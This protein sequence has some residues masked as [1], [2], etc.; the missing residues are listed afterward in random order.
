[1]PAIIRLA[2]LIGALSHALDLTGGQDPGHCIRTA[3]IGSAV[4]R[5]LGLGEAE[6]HDLYYTLML[7]DLGCSAN[8]MRMC[9]LFDTDDT[10]FKRDFKRVDGSLPSLLGQVL[11]H[12]GSR[13]GPLGRFRAIVAALRRGRHAR[14]LVEIRCQRGA[15]IARQMRFSQAVAAGIRDL[16]EH[17]DGSGRPA[18]LKA[19]EIH[20]SARIALAAQLLDVFNTRDGCDAARAEIVRRRGQWLDPKVVDALLAVTDEPG[21]WDKLAAPDLEAIVLAA[22]PGQKVI[23]A[24]EDYLDDIVEGFARVIDAKSPYT[25]GH[26]DR[27]AEFTVKIAEELGLSEAEQRVLRRAALLHDIGKLGVS[28]RI[29]NKPAK[30]DPE[31]W[32]EMR[33]H[34]AHSERILSRIPAFA[35]LAE[36]GGA[37]HERLDGKGYPRGLKGGEISF[38]T[39]IVATADVFEALTGERPY[40][41]AIP[42]A[43]ALAMMRTSQGDH[44]DPVCVDALERALSRAE[45]KAA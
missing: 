21:F 9:E 18:G 35:E 29:L 45:L 27:V 23:L 25:A 38:A 13:R 8:A 11:R 42:A 20:L 22:E 39:R 16:D 10:R 14:E 36:V 7:K 37:H 32:Q 28:A 24:D 4:G 34:A 40:R 2:E 3:H 1:M 26:S 31:E 43:T 12:A 15:E 19:G 44:H 30:L 33:G 17:Y 6:L 5:R 41:A